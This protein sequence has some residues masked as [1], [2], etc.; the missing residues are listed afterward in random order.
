MSE[1]LSQYRVDFSHGVKLLQNFQYFTNFSRF[2]KAVL[3]QYLQYKSFANLN[4]LS[5]DGS[6]VYYSIV[7]VAHA[8]DT[9]SRL[10]RSNFCRLYFCDLFFSIL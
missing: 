9:R 2:N 7:V 6:L 5:R 10:T 4:F 8:V 1:C 3:T